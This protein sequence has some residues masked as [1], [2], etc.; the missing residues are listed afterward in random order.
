[1]GYKPAKC[2][3][4]EKKGEERGEDRNQNFFSIRD[5]CIIY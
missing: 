1:M 4:W 3:V 2:W 5:K